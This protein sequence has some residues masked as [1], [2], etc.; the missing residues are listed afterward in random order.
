MEIRAWGGVCRLDQNVEEPGAERRGLG[1]QARQGG[2]AE[3]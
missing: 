3:A 1:S 2:E